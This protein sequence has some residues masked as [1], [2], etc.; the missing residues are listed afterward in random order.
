MAENKLRN[1]TQISKK[2]ALFILHCLANTAGELLCHLGPQDQPYVRAERKVRRLSSPT[3]RPDRRRQ[4]DS[5]C[6]FVQKN[7][8]EAKLNVVVESLSAGTLPTTDGSD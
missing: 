1:F 3:L 8:L 2:S 6:S 5:G 4:D 7:Y